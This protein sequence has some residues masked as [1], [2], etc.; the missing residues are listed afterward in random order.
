MAILHCL[1]RVFC[2]KPTARLPGVDNS[3]AC[4]YLLPVELWLLIASFLPLAS[5]SS[6]AFTSRRLASIFGPTCWQ[7]LGK[8]PEECLDFLRLLDSQLP[9]HRLCSSCLTYHLRSKRRRYGECESWLIIGFFV[10]SLRF[11]QVQLAIRAERLGPQFGEPVPPF[12]ALRSIVPRRNPAFSNRFDTAIV[13]GRL[14]FRL[15]TSIRISK[16]TETYQDN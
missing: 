1:R 10:A 11:S 9:K 4:V 13:D 7:E 2:L 5:Q 15:E 6:L 3:G 8:Y 14:L 16:F 12:K